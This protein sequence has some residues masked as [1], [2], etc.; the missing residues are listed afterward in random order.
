MTADPAPGQ[1]ATSA[2]AIKRENLIRKELG[3]GRP[4]D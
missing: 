4:V 1:R 3:L 2:C